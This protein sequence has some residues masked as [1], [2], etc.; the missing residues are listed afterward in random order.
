MKQLWLSVLL[1]DTSVTTGIRTHILLLTPEL[2]SGKLDRSATTPQCANKSA[3]KPFGKSATPFYLYLSWF[4]VSVIWQSS[5]SMNTSNTFCWIQ[6]QFLHKARAHFRDRNQT[7]LG[8][9]HRLSVFA[10]S[11]VLRWRHC[12][13]QTWTKVCDRLPLG[14]KMADCKM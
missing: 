9:G 14:F 2:E 6:P 4:V 7:C 13:D 11:V 10:S 12:S 1:K 8:F 5:V 3:L